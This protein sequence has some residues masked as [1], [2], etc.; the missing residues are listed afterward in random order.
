MSKK[1]GAISVCALTLYPFD[2][3]PGQRFRIE[4]WQPFLEEQGISIDY[5]SFADENLTK[6]MPKP[7]NLPTKVG[8]MLKGVAKRFAHLRHL[9]KYDVILIYRA[10]AMIGPAFFERLIKLSGRPVVFDFDDAIF[11]ENTNE[12]NKLFGWLKFPEKTGS[13]CRLSTS[14]T[15]GNEWLGEYAA[16][17]NPNVTIIPSSVN[18]DIYV[19]VKK[20]E[21]PPNDKIIL[22]WT[23][24]STSQT[25]L[26]MFAPTLKKFLESRDD[27]ELHVHSDRSPDL[28]GI[29]FVW[30]QWS[31][32]NEVEVIS[33]FD[34]GIMP[35]PDDEWSRGKCSMKALLYMSLAIP[36]VCSDVGMNREVINQ[37]ENGFL[38]SSEEEWLKALNAL[39]D[40][41]NLRQRLGHAARETVLEKYSM[42]RC[43]DL[44]GEVI[45]NS[46]IINSGKP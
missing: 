5:Y 27:V 13:I 31:P 18:T 46:I 30:H 16:K 25:H 14:V 40:D 9:S 45:R 17:F 10:A 44:F 3:V 42:K 32:E 33:N 37:G 43:A 36:T 12:A 35:L 38:V 20:V 21:A 28:P 8:G 22:G 39:A 23:G 26:E 19:P 34:I 24:S 15:V 29:P 2:T 1:N 41:R 7:G 6:I 11:L 4:Q